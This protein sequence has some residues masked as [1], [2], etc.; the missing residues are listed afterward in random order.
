VVLALAI[1][2]FAYA[3]FRYRTPQSLSPDSKFYAAMAE[4]HAVPSPYARRWLLP[5][6]LKN[7]RAWNIAS[8]VAF[9]ATGPLVYDLTGSLACVWL[10][11]W[12][13]GFA[14]N[15]RFPVLTDQVAVALML[16]AAVLCKHDL[17]VPAMVAL[18]LATQCKEAAVLGGLLCMSP[19]SWVGAGAGL[20]TALWVGHRSP[21]EQTE[22]YMLHP[23]RDA[24]RRHDPLCWRSML[25]PWGAIPLLCVATW[26]GLGELE[27]VACVSLVLAYGQLAIA[28]DESRLFLWAAPAVL[29]A[30]S[31][32]GLDAPWLGLMLVVHPFACGM[33]KRV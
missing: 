8:G 6:L 18:F 24:L 30:L 25:L 10:W 12:L 23:F 29:M 7:A 4:G 21:A 26:S 9:V 28:R 17:Q 27:A 20:L 33:V 19:L 15:V 32:G 5:R 13:P 11:A 1:Q 31:A 14:V 2:A 16:L 3:V 22:E